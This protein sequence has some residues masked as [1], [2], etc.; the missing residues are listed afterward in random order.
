LITLLLPDFFGNFMHGNY[1]GYANNIGPAIYIGVL[2]LLLAITAVVLDRRDADT[3]FFAATALI[4]LAILT[5]HLGGEQVLQLPILRSFTNN[6]FIAPFTLSMAFLAGKGT[7]LFWARPKAVLKVCAVL[8][9][10]G[11]V[12]VLVAFTYFW[13]WLTAMKRT[14]HK[15]TCGC[16]TWPAAASRS[17][18]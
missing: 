11:G 13:P 5:K 10:A 9:A 14:K 15:A 8:F 7:D 1:W 2:P 17:L 18:C 6:K 3:I 16:S 4:C 12:F